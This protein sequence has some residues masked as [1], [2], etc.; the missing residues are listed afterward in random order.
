MRNKKWKLALAA[1][2]CT[3]AL[4]SGAAMAAEALP[5]PAEA[6]AEAETISTEAEV[7]PTEEERLPSEESRAL[8]LVVREETAIEVDGETLAGPAEVRGTTWFYD[9]KLAL[10][11]HEVKLSHPRAG[12]WDGFL[13]VTQ[14]YPEGGVWNLSAKLDYTRVHEVGEKVSR[15]SERWLEPLV[16]EIAGERAVIYQEPRETAAK[17]AELLKGAKVTA[18]GCGSESGE[19]LAIRGETLSVTFEDGTTRELTKAERFTL[20]D[21]MGGRATCEI[22][23]QGEKHLFLVS[24]ADIDFARPWYHVE[25]TGE[26]G[27]FAGWAR[28]EDVKAPDK[29]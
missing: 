4:G 12:C 3:T 2:L 22:E 26:A 25:G 8:R 7:L 20:V 28:A 1:F 29:K 21:R 27:P 16:L 17:V 19:E 13:L 9:A 14:D 24:E 23:T 18:F 11:R 15:L 6:A 5:L 10:G